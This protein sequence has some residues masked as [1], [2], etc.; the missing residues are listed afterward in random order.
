MKRIIMYTI[1]FSVLWFLIHSAVIITD[2]LNDEMGASD[3]GVILGTKVNVDGSL[4]ERLQK[5]LDKGI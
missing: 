1:S 3:I 5:R 2:G 4:S